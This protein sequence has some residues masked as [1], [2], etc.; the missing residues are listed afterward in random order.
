MI[1]DYWKPED[2][3]HDEEVQKRL[4]RNESEII[5]VM[6]RNLREQAAV[7][8]TVE[9]ET[10]NRCNNDCSFCPANRNA[11]IRPVMKME[12]WVFEKIID[13]L[14]DMDYRGRISLFSNDEPLLDNR[15]FDFLS[16]AR[17]KLP[18][19]YHS[20]F[21]NGILLTDDKFDKLVNLLDYL[22]INNYN[23]DLE[24]DK[25]IQKIVENNHDEKKCQVMIEVRKKNQVLMNRGGLSPN[26][27]IYYHYNSACILPFVQMVIR[28][29]GGVSRCCQD[30]YGN[31]TLG[32]VK[33]N[34]IQEIWNGEKYR[35]YREK[36]LNGERCTVSYCKDCDING[37]VNCYPNDWEYL[38][39]QQM[40]DIIKNKYLSSRKICLCCIPDAKAITSVLNTQG[41]AVE[42]TF[43]KDDLEAY[44]DDGYFIVMSYVDK[45]SLALLDEKK[46]VLGEDYLIYSRQMTQSIQR[47]SASERNVNVQKLKDASE[48]NRLIVFGAGTTANRLI[49]SLK[50]KPLKIVD[51]YKAGIE[52]CNVVV[53]KPTDVMVDPEYVFLVA[54]F[55]YVEVVRQLNAMGISS[56]RIILGY[57]L[58]L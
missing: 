50:L 43:L 20:L 32:N 56:Q 9:I 8:S 7:L 55:D 2:M 13:E 5:D 17:K 28:P 30:V 53:E 52:F 11:D 44:I 35:Q 45:M 29:D 18:N 34:T 22:R 51:N 6:L 19:A 47:I 1:I 46:V 16:Y 37:L 42:C 48:E 58:L 31:E 40:L 41:V 12:Q 15:I 33:D 21:T 10:I 54:A 36:M 38:Y 39:F 23:D 26:N 49:S 24:L 3:T 57:K 4:D 27:E 25:N 14:A